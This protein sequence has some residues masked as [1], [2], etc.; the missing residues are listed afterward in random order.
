[1]PAPP[2]A[3]ESVLWAAS[4]CPG[5]LRESGESIGSSFFQTSGKG[6][7]FW[8]T[9]LV[10]MAGGAHASFSFR[11]LDRGPGEAGG[12]HV[13]KPQPRSVLK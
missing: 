13:I 6:A 10:S 12:G 8:K 1:M 5:L 4:L 9:G 7:R 11:S 3:A 2:A